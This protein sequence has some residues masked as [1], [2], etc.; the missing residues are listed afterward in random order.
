MLIQHR[1][2]ELFSYD[3]ETGLF[4]RL[5]NIKGQ[6][7]GIVRNTPN[8]KGYLC[9]LIDNKIYQQ[10]RLAFLYMIGR[11]P[12]I[13]DHKDGDGANNKWDNLREATNSQNLRNVGARKNNKLGVKGVM[14]TKHGFAVTM[15][16]G[17]YK[18]IEEAIEVYN[19]AAKLFHG[20]F[21][22]LQ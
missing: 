20:E 13:I 3:P 17:T 9:L 2:K 12:T 8:R 7:A 4:T 5:K 1:L 19:K 16:L 6:Y 18:T 22:F 21:A 15:G 14:Q 10:H 11:W